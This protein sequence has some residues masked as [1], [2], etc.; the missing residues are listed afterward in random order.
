MTTQQIKQLYDKG[1]SRREIAEEIE[2]TEVY[3]DFED[4]MQIIEEVLLQL[5]RMPVGGRK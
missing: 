5:Q 3:I 4:A 2:F 1:W